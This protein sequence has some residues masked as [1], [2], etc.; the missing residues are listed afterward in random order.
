MLIMINMIAMII[1]VVMIRRITMSVMIMKIASRPSKLV[2]TPGPMV[3][4]W[5]Y[6]GRVLVVH[7][8]SV[9]TEPA[10]HCHPI[11]LTSERAA[12][13]VAIS[14]IDLDRSGHSCHEFGHDRPRSTTAFVRFD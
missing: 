6:G 13:S 7:C 8:Y 10:V 2:P 9:G 1:I 4:H 5:W 12:S 3:L 11:S 14:Y